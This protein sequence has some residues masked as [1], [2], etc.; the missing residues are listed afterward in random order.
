MNIVIIIGLNM[1]VKRYFPYFI[2]ETR[3]VQK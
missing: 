1:S 3:V 2:P